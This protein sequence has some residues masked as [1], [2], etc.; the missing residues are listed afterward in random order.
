MKIKITNG[1][2]EIIDENQPLYY[3]FIQD[4]QYEYICGSLLD[5][6]S[7]Q[8]SVKLGEKIDKV[9]TLGRF[10][11]PVYAFLRSNKKEYDIIMIYNPI[12]NDYIPCN[13]KNYITVMTNIDRKFKLFIGEKLL[14]VKIK[15]MVNKMVDEKMKEL[16]ERRGSTLLDFDGETIE[17]I[18]SAPPDY[19]ESLK[20]EP[21]IVKIHLIE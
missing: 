9:F 15:S 2:W 1:I 17:T 21:Q 16:G 20:D 8:W 11:I 13:N 7:E 5:L 18:S 3:E 4:D 12:T 10:Y 6:T 14:E 19:E